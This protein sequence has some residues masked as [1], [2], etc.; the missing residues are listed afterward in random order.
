MKISKEVKVGLFMISSIVLLYLGFNFLKGIDFFS[1]DKKY[2]AIFKNIDGLTESNQILLN[3]APIGRVSEIIIQQSR[4]RVVVELSIDSEIIVTK[5]SVAIL[6]GDLLGG[7]FLQVAVGKPDERLQPKDTIQSAVAKG[8]VDVI[9]ESAAPVASNLQ[10]TL[11]KMNGVLDSLA[12]TANLINKVLE[13]FQSTPRTLNSTITSVKGNLE[14]LS[15]TY[16]DVGNN[17]NKTLADLKPTLDNFKTLSDSLKMMQLNHTVN[18]AQE[19]I[20]N[21]NSTLA[22]LNKGDNTASKLLTDDAL[23]VNLNSLLHNLDSLANHFNENPRHFMAP[24]G[25]SKK[26]IQKELEQERKKKN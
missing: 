19:A 4:D 16:Q 10:T 24:L 22:K 3:G 2:F 12:I 13:N 15:G 14:K 1:S 7:R 5:S 8:L 6:N 18:K 20:S 23:Y 11:G 17:L 21:L 25:K 26:Q 9:S